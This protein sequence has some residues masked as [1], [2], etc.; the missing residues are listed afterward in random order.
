MN[1]LVVKISN[2]ITYIITFLFI[3]EKVSALKNA[4]NAFVSVFVLFRQ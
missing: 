4:R 3:T 2:S 1:A